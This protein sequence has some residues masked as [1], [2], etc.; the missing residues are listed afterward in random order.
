MSDEKPDPVK[1]RF[2]IVQSALTSLAI[3]VGGGY[4]LYQ[5]SIHRD[6]WD[7]IA[8]DQKIESRRID[9]Q[10]IWLTASV[11]VR[12][13]SKVAVKL[14]KAKV[15]F[16]QVLPAPAEVV[17]AIHDHKTNF[18]GDGKTV[19]DWPRLCTYEQNIG[20]QLEPSETDVLTVDAFIP[21]TL[22]TVKVFTFMSDPQD[23]DTGWERSTIYDLPKEQTN[24]TAEGN[25][26]RPVQPLCP[27]DKQP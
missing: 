12:N 4:A 26:A 11:S 27:G 17:T 20:F 23:P 25:N 16:Y 9:S 22:R 14:P 24:D 13:D 15:I 10:F 7:L 1:R 19:T 6:N 18:T 21:A 8:V 2:E 3:I 5:C